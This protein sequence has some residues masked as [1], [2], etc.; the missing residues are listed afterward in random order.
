MIDGS[1]FLCFISQHHRHHHRTGRIKLYHIAN[2]LVHATRASHPCGLHRTD[3][4]SH[5]V[6]DFIAKWNLLLYYMCACVSIY[7]DKIFCAFAFNS[8]RETKGEKSSK[9]LKSHFLSGFHW[10]S[11]WFA[12]NFSLNLRIVI[13]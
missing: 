4:V 6:I 1:L 3:D 7:V 11:E 13:F 2:E 12:V 9:W 8:M 5:K 10:M